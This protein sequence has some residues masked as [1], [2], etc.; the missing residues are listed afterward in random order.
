M[1]YTS[2][3]QIANKFPA[4]MNFDIVVRAIPRARRAFAYGDRSTFIKVLNQA[5]AA[6]P[7]H[8]D[9]QEVL[10]S[11]VAAYP[12]VNALR[13]LTEADKQVKQVRP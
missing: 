6:V 4:T 9:L 3:E 7:E 8:P 10:R 2:Y 1:I 11:A 5:I 13:L 12:N